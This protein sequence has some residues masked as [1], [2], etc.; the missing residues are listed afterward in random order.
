ML[1]VVRGEGGSSFMYKGFACAYV[2]VPLWIAVSSGILV[3]RQFPRETHHRNSG[4]DPVELYAVAH[5]STRCVRGPL[6]R[7]LF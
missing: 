7:S 6:P 3:P 4:R 2:S 5:A 1:L